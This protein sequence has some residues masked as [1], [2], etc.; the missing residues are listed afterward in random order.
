M[1]AGRCTMRPLATCH[2]VCNRWFMSSSP[3]VH[4]S[5]RLANVEAAL[6]AEFDSVPADLVHALIVREARHYDAAKIHDFVP[7][8]VTRSVRG[9]LREHGDT[10]Q[11]P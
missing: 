5:T 10:I 8:L 6:I 3:A 7:L 4:P 2:V 1:S 9:R 11:L